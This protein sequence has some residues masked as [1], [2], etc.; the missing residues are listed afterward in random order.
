[1]AAGLTATDLLEVPREQY[2]E[3]KVACEQASRTIVGDRLL[4]DLA[5]PPQI[6][7]PGLGCRNALKREAGVVAFVVVAHPIPGRLQALDFADG[8]PTPD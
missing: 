5:A 6:R 2:G 8:R 3:A 1:V 4:V 7:K